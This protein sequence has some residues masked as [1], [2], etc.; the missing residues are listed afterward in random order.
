M[1]CAWGEDG[2]A[3]RQGNN[4]LV[5]SPIFPPAKV[6][7]T[8]AA[9]DSFN[10]GTIHALSSGKTLQEALVFGCKVAGVK[11]GMRGLTGIQN[12]YSQ[13]KL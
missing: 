11:V 13:N 6:V 10:A 2:A 4:P 9:G 3:G 8:L 7:D 1:I 12:W 5:S